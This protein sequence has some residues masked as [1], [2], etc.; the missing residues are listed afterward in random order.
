MANSLLTPSV[1]AKEALLTLENNL[2]LGNLVHTDYSDEFV[3]VD[4]LLLKMLSPNSV[5]VQLSRVKPICASA[6]A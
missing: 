4:A 3:K 6:R 2:V 5:T 1:I